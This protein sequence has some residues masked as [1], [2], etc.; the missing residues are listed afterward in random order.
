M[1][2]ASRHTPMHGILLALRHL[3]C[4]LTFST[5]TPAR[6]EK[7]SGGTSE[8]TGR[9]NVNLK[10]NIEEWR[11]VMKDML[12]FSTR[13]SMVALHVVAGILMFLFFI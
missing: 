10:D 8:V 9:V 5:P 7:G 2:H 13:A 3:I 12:E 1:Q 11:A 6:K 4:E